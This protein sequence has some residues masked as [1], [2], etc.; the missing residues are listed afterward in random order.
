MRAKEYYEEFP[1][2]LINKDKVL[3]MHHKTIE[4]VKG[5]IDKLTKR[6]FPSNSHYDFVSRK[7][8]KAELEKMKI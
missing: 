7:E 2:S 1:Y 5:L 3:E 8:I 6:I 4:D